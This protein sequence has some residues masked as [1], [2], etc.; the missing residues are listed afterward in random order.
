MTIEPP[1]PSVAA[2][3][4][5]S[6]YSL[7]RCPAEIDGV[8]RPDDDT[9][10][11]G[12]TPRFGA[13]LRRGW[14]TP[15]TWPCPRSSRVFCLIRSWNLIADIPYWVIAALVLFALVVNSVNA[16]FWVEHS[17]GW[18]LEVRVAVEMAVI[19]VVIYGIGW[20]PILAIGFVFGA[21][22][23]MRSAGS[24]A[25]RPA[26]IWTLFCI[27]VGQLAIAVGAAPTL[28]HQPLVDSLGVLDALGA[29]FTI[30]VLPVVCRGPRGQ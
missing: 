15:P 3:S 9:P 20:G 21:V 24:A 1:R 2:E 14:R 23:V 27:A 30:K 19:A 10:E 25:A 16:A 4:S 18:R 7:Q 28:I 11:L 22:D 8:S 12:A 29:V 26:I 17:A 13:R 6:G 5:I